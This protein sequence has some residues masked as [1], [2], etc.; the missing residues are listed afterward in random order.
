MAD[1]RR[2]SRRNACRTRQSSSNGLRKGLDSDADSSD[3]LRD[4]KAL[5]SAV[6][7][8]EVY[9]FQSQLVCISF[10]LHFIFFIRDC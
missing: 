3:G 8:P 1:S 4:F 5:L 10:F 7:S 9:G 2:T 6:M